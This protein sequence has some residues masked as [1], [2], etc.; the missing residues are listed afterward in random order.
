MDDKIKVCFDKE[1]RVRVLDPVKSNRA[2]DLQKE[3]GTFGESMFIYMMLLMI[4][5]TVYAY[6]LLYLCFLLQRYHLL[7]RK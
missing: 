2:E 7:V 5:C 3:C 4:C 6:F 1:Y